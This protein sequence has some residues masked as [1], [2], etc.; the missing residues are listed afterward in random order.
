MPCSDGYSTAPKESM[1]T[2]QFQKFVA[3]M[4]TYRFNFVALCRCDEDAFDLISATA[5]SRD[6]SGPGGVW[7]ELRSGVISR[8][9]S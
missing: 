2:E 8:Y 6:L 9:L 4:L 7:R 5:Q 1:I 3:L